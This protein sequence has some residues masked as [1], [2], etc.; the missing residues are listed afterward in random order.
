MLCPPTKKAKYHIFNMAYYI[1]IG[2]FVNLCA[3]ILKKS[4]ILI[5]V[6]ALLEEFGGIKAKRTPKMATGLKKQKPSQLE[7]LLKS[8]NFSDLPG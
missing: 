5:L 1:I 3:I 7:W 4:L 2:V 8:I 6:R